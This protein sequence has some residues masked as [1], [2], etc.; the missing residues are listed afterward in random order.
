[1]DR[2]VIHR[3][4]GAAE[5]ARLAAIVNSMPPLASTGPI[6]WPAD[7]VDTTDTLR[8]TTGARYPH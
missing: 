1:M 2:P 8:F 6:D 7:Y 3:V 5:A 4:F